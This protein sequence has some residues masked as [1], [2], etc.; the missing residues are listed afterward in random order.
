[1]NSQIWKEMLESENLTRKEVMKCIDSF[2]C[3]Y[4]NYSDEIQKKSAIGMIILGIDWLFENGYTDSILS[5]WVRIIEENS[6]E[7][8]PSK[9]EFY[10]DDLIQSIECKDD[11]VDNELMFYFQLMGL[12]YLIPKYSRI[13]EKV[14]STL[15]YC[16]NLF[17]NKLIDDEKLSIIRN[18]YYRLKTQ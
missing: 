9:I 10:C 3:Q 2:E 8:E 1:M 15:K 18:Q 11:I 7:V 17:S 5:K 13:K 6:L 16:R 14:N 4:Y 12:D